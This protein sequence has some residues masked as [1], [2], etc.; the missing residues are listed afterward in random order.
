MDV[1]HSLTLPIHILYFQV[2]VPIPHSG[3]QPPEPGGGPIPSKGGDRQT[4][5]APEPGL[6]PEPERPRPSDPHP[7]PQRGACT[8]E[9]STWSKLAHQPQPPQ[10]EI[11]PTPQ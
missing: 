4:A 3:N 7:H 9:R 6:V 8:K 5:K 11:I 2:Q 10:D 1:V